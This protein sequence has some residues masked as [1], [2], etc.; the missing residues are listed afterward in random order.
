MVIL[1]GFKGLPIWYNND[2]KLND[3]KKLISTSNSNVPISKTS[4][5]SLVVAEVS[6]D[7]IFRCC[8]TLLASTLSS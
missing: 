7:P 4:F 5:Q 6:F 1:W 2:D 8:C 3:I